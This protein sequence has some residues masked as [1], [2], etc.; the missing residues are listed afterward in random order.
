MSETSFYDLP[1]AEQEQLVT[2][3]TTLLRTLSS[4]TLK[5]KT[6]H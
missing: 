3:I 4:V 5:L 6:N 1:K 2:Q